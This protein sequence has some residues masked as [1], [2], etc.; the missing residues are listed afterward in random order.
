MMTN[1]ELQRA[2]EKLMKRVAELEA[3]VIVPPGTPGGWLFDDADNSGHALLT[4]M[5]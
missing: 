1:L 2:I 4:C 3:G 5:D